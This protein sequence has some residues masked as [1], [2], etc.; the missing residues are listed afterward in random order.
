MTISILPSY[1]VRAVMKWKC[2]FVQA[3]AIAAVATLLVTLPGCG[4]GSDPD[5][6]TGGGGTGITPPPEPGS[7]SGPVT[8]L[9]PLGVAGVSLDATNIS[10]LVNAAGAKP[11]TDLR[12]GMTVDATALLTAGT[13]EGKAS[14]LVVQSLVRGPVSA[15]D[16]AAQTVTTV[17]VV[18]QVD[19]NTILENFSSLSVLRRGDRIEVYGLP[20]LQ[21][22]RAL[23]TRIILNRNAAASDPV[24]VLGIATSV[25]T[26]TVT[27]GGN[28][29]T[30]TQAQI[31]LAS[32]GAASAPLPA[33]TVVAANTRVRVVG[34]LDNTGAITAT[35]V[36]VGLSP[37]RLIGS[38]VFLEGTVLATNPPV[39]NIV[40]IGEDKVDLSGLPASTAALI[41]PGVRAQVRGRKQDTQVLATE[42]RVFA[43]TDRLEYQVEG[44]IAD[45]TSSASFKVAG[46][47]ISALT[48]RFANGA[49]AAD[50]GAGKRVRIKG[51]AGAGILD[52]TEVTLL[53]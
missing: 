42:G 8:S 14:T 1:V 13:T 44:I 28:A 46:E 16:I 7:S 33:G 37:Q 20:Q 18:A 12:L 38:L 36:V 22:G 29:V 35:Q 32:G 34:T 5:T 10:A 30:T 6:K 24:E 47:A 31:I 49:T 21:S 50:L 3:A 4:G 19:Q 45:F 53:P 17:G 27:V 48:A 41:V 9:S 39:A 40:Q 2:N 11:S 51:V 15:I 26:T 43:S 23:A 52:A 25:T